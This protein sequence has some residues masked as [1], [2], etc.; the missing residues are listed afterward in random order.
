MSN[1]D[2]GFD[3]VQSGESYES[4]LN[5]PL[6]PAAPAAPEKIVRPFEAYRERR[7]QR[8]AQLRRL[9]E[10][11]N[12]AQSCWGGVTNGD[13]VAKDQNELWGQNV[14]TH[15]PNEDDPAPDDPIDENWVEDE[16]KYELIRVASEED[17]ET[18]VVIRV[19][20]ESYIQVPSL[21]VSRTSGSGKNKQTL[22]FTI[23][24]RT[25]RI[26]WLDIPPGEE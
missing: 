7:D 3:D 1:V 22:N 25:V 17:P 4:T 9:P 12:V 10:D 24:E 26:K 15:K 13:E 21:T 14:T 6:G 23:P 8:L 18:F 11:D 5:F 19:A 20:R 16:R 2:Y